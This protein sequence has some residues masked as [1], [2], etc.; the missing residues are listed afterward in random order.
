MKK[1]VII[2]GSAGGIG[3]ALVTEFKKN[4]Y[5]TIGID[6]H[7]STYAD[8]NIS[9]DLSNL[10]NNKEVETK[11]YAQVIEALAGSELVL[12]INNA[13]VQILDGIEDAGLADFKK[14]MD[15]NLTAPFLLSQLFFEKLKASRGSIIN[16]GSIHAKQT[17]PKFIAYATSKSAL[18]G[19]TQAMAVDF[20]QHV[21]VNIIQPAAISTAMLIDGFKD[22]P[23]NLKQLKSFHPSGII[24][25][26]EDVARLAM[27]LSR[28]GSTFING[29]SID[30]DGAIG[31]RLHDPG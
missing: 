20:G 14:T 5:Q 22:N 24:G 1:A 27:F 17:K 11:L 15:V 29:S 16:I 4:G 7:H 12:L 25:S 19:L 9:C 26:P 6:Q 8:I 13:A 3:V 23:E 21:R 18:K 31:A 10:V 30:I 28:D 2:T